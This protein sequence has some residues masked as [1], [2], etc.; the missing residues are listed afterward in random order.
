VQQKGRL[1]L[2]QW[3]AA[4]FSSEEAVPG[5]ARAAAAKVVKRRVRASMLEESE[6]EKNDVRGAFQRRYCS[7]LIFQEPGFPSVAQSRSSFVL[8]CGH[9]S[10]FYQAL[11]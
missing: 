11:W 7:S 6:R 10:G 1:G 5:D 3:V 8:R 2:S 4:L 9:G